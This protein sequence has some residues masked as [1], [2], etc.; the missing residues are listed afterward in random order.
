MKPPHRRLCPSANRGF[1]LVEVMIVVVIIA[2]LA[3]LAIPAFQRVRRAAQNSRIENDLRVFSQ[4][5]ETYAAEKGSWPAN[6]GPGIVPTG[7][8]GTFKTTVWQAPT[9]IGGTWN[10]D[11]GIS[12]ITAGI[13]ISGFT[14]D[15]MQ[16]TEIDAKID[17]GDLTTGNFQKV[18]PTRVTLILQL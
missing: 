18:Q 16:L 6:V 5:F 10:W 9:E 17:D 7:M 11:T 1:T 13:S 14:C 4:A 3:A 2:L 8:A 15:D 12:G